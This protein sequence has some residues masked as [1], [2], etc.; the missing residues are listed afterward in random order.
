MVIFK[1]NKKGNIQDPF[2][3]ITIFFGMAIAFIIF[4]YL[5][6]EFQI[7]LNPIL[8]NTVSADILAETVTALGMFDMIFVV[9]VVFLMISVM[10]S[11]FFIRS[12]PIF[13]FVLL[14]LLGL[15]IMIAAIFSNAFETFSEEERLSVAVEEFNLTRYVMDKLPYFIGAFFILMLIFLVSRIGYTRGYIEA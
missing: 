7:Q 5:T 8:D 11:A 6:I 1:K 2:L 12:H 3:A 13:F 4:Y 10:I 14:P 9:V 15:S